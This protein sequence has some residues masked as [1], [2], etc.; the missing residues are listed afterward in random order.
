MARNITRGTPYTHI[1]AGS[2]GIAPGQPKGADGQT[3][4][5]QFRGTGMDTTQS[6]RGTP[7]TSRAGN[8]GDAKRTA[9]QGK[10]GAVIDAVAGDQGNHLSNGSGVVFDGATE[11]SNGYMP[12]GAAALDSPVPA[13]A[14]QFDPGQVIVENLAHLG[15]GQSPKLVDGNLVEIGGVMSRGL[16]STSKSGAGEEELTTDDTLPG[17]APAG[18]A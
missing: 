10:Y 5:R 12:G 11:V 16:V 1:Q 18:K 8:P 13:S 4:M 7:Y 15:K 17:V 14:P 2:G 3:T 9:S 6:A